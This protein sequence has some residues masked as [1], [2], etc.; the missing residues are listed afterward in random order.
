MRRCG[1]EFR[2][3]RVVPTEDVA[4]KFDDR[5]LH[6]EADA[7]VRDAVLARVLSG[8]DHAL[9][10]AVAETAG[11][12]DAAAPAELLRDVVAR[13]CFRVDPLDINARVAGRARVEERFNDAEISVVQADVLADKR[14]AHVAVDAVNFAHQRAPLGH[15]GFAAV[16]AQL[17]AHH[18]AEA[19]VL[20]QQRHFVERGRRR[21]LDDA[22]GLH[23]AEER[24]LAADVV[25]DGLVRA[26]DEDVGLDALAQKLFDRV[27]RGLALELTAAGDRH[28]ERHVDEEHIFTPALSRDLT[29]GL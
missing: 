23:V 8:Q 11:D 26:H 24:D 27:L 12:Q 22:V 13:Q 7:E 16:E 14:D 19:L 21:V 15:V 25:G 18:V 3:R 4:R 5:D 17:A 29:D 1:G 20:E 9:D 6:A 10:A 28:D 2:A